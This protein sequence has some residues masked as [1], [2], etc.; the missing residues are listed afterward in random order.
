MSTNYISQITATDGVTY[1]VQEGVTTRIFRATCSTANATAAKVATLDDSTGYSL[2][3]GVRVAVTFTYGNTATSP[4]LN[5]NSGGAKYIYYRTDISSAQKVDELCVWGANETVIFTYNGSSWIMMGSSL[6]LYNAYNKAASSGSGTITEVKTNAGAHTT[7]DVLSGKAEF[8]V[9]TTAAHVG[10]ATSDHAHGNITNGGD[11]TATAPTIANGDQIIINDN[12]A[13]KITNGPTF[14]GSTTTKALTPKGTWETFSSTDTKVTQTPLNATNAYNQVIVTAGNIS[15]ETTSTVSFAKNLTYNDYTPTLKL[16]KNSDNTKNISITGEQIA[17]TNGSYAT[18]LSFTTPTTV[19]KTIT[20]PNATGTVALTSDI[21]TNTDEKLAVSEAYINANYS[22]LLGYGE[23]AQTRQLDGG[24]W[25][26]RT[27]GTPATANLYIGN[28]GHSSGNLILE[29]GISHYTTINTDTQTANRIITLPDK[30]GTVALTSDIPTETTV[31]GWGFTKNTG[32]LTGVTFAGTSMSVSSG[33]ASITQANARTAL[34]LATVATS[35]SYDDLSNKPTI[36]AN[37]DEKV[38][39]TSN[40]GST[41][42]PLVL[43]PTSITSGTAYNCLYNTSLKFTPST[44][45][46]ETTQLNGVTVGLSPKFTDSEV[47]T[48][49]LASGSTTGTSLSFGSKYTLTAGSKTVSF[50]MPSSPTDTKN[51]AGSTNSASKLYLI[52]AT[53]QSANPQTYSNSRLYYS[54]GLQSESGNNNACTRIAQSSSSLSVVYYDAS[55]SPD[56]TGLFITSSGN[57][58]TGLVTPTNNSDAANKKYVDDNKGS[59]VK[60][61]RW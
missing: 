30:T 60:I 56:T 7:I 32:T 42:V 22:V 13:S 28:S 18:K 49:T 48:L 14:D 10:A 52:G 61:T 40:T 3:A 55:L 59:K 51:T 9:P 53:E 11:I 15:S 50:T 36:P 43:G 34:G 44:G 20:F 46:L 26:Q 47:S 24:L 25:Y 12:S 16:T 17:I 2:A 45:N 1:D 29:D 23:S 57:S 37:T 33:V 41:A 58:L 21:P 6:A 8:N 4:T 35:G 5:V 54:S 27:S 31:S 38:K 19:D 39:L